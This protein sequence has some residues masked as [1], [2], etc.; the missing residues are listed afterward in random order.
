MYQSNRDNPF[1]SVC[2]H[3]AVVYVLVTVFVC[4]YLQAQ[5]FVALFRKPDRRPV[6][7]AAFQ[8]DWRPIS[9]TFVAVVILATVKVF[10]V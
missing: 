3:V 6:L 1:L 4:T 5:K 9:V 2:T 7:V 10:L 8:I